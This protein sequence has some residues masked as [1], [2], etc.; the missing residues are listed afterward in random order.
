MHKT[1]VIALTSPPTG[2]ML[3]LML[4]VEDG[5]DGQPQD[6]QQTAISDLWLAQA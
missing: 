2:L 6:Q 1:F 3:L 4:R 5:R